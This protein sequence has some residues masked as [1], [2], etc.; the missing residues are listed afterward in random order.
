MCS[1]KVENDVTI[2]LSKMGKTRKLPTEGWQK[3][4]NVVSGFLPK[5]KDF[6]TVLIVTK[7]VEQRSNIILHIFFVKCKISKYKLYLKKCMDKNIKSHC[8]FYSY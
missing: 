6:T 7:K 5:L 1:L 2:S 8:F 3:C 4:I